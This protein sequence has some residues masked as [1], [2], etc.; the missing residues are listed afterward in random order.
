VARRK[1]TAKRLD[2]LLV[3][4]LWA[5]QLLLEARLDEQLQAAGMT[6]AEFRLIGELLQAPNGLRQNELAKRLG[7]RAPTISASVARLEAAGVVIRN[8]DSTDPR[9]RIVSLAPGA[10]IDV[11]VDLLENLEIRIHKALS[12]E[13]FAQF[14]QMLEK[15]QHELLPLEMLDFRTSNSELFSRKEKA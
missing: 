3:L 4:R 5:T 6:I 13:E 2:R 15:I 14:D 12:K 8:A 9:A 7:V 1:D 10:P 11:G